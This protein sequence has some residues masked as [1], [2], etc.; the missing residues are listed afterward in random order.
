MTPTSLLSHSV[1]VFDCYGTLIDWE[2]GIWT[3][4]Q[5]IASKNN[6]TSL[7]RS[8]F[9]SLY[10]EFEAK[11]QRE[12]PDILYY[13][14]LAKIHPLICER[15]GY[16]MLPS[17]EESR[18]FGKSVGEW[19]AFPDTVDALSKLKQAGLKLVIL[20]NVDRESF[21]KT[22]AVSGPLEGFP[23]DAIITAQDVGSYKPDKR[24]FEYMLEFVEGEFGVKKEEVLQVA[25]SQFH[26]HQPAKREGLDSA[27][28][29]RVG[30][31]MGQV[32]KGEEK[33]DWRMETLGEFAEEVEMGK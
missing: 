32:S 21:S 2:T 9:L 16:A 12:T 17:E 24:N 18:L 10:H 29:D 15:L 11:Q 28:I 3:A 20:S 27:W 4:F 13:N 14:L 8:T 5:S 26:D 19:P 33:W 30:A 25:Q 22:N 7:T 31:V 6:D 1:L 23:F